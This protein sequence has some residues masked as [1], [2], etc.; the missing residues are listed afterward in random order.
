MTTAVDN[1]LAHMGIEVGDELK[2]Y[3]KK[4]MKWGQRKA[5]KVA[6]KAA[7]KEAVAESDRQIIAARLRNDKRTS[8]MERLAAK[9][10]TEKTQKGRDLATKAFE[11][12]AEKSFKHPDAEMSMKMTSGEARAAK[13][14]MTLN[15]SLVGIGLLGAAAVATKMR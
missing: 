11:K 4:G 6:A 2:H 14:D 7:K 10:F 15:L 9:T 13:I 3:G 1:Y 5:E 12:Y 8:E